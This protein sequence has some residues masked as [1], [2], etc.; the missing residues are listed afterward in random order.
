MRLAIFDLDH[1]LLEGDCD[2]LWGDFIS[3]KGL[4]DVE[5]YQSQKNRYFS[6]YQAGQLDI[7]SFLEFSA[8][9]LATFSHSELK[10]LGKEFAQVKVKPKLRPR[11]IDRLQQHKENND[12]CLVVTATNHFLAGWATMHLP[13]DGLIASELEQING[14][15]T[16]N[17]KGL[18]S[19]QA[20]KIRRLQMWLAEKPYSLQQSTFYSDSHNDLPLLREVEVPVV[21]SPDDTLR[22]V[23]QNNNWP[24]ENWSIN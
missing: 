20:G 7:Q 23:A 3:E 19:Y 24:I 10:E 5:F 12:C 16:G 9:T 14:N 21:I 4:V 17:I 6:E 2:Q 1:T 15:Y 22:E 13:I 18:P 11:G 8:K